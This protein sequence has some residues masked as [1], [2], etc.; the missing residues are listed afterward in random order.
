MFGS[1]FIIKY[2]KNNTK[3]GKLYSRHETG[4]IAVFNPMGEIKPLYFEYQDIN[5]KLSQIKIDRILDSSKEHF[6]GLPTIIYICETFINERNVQ[7]GLRYHVTGHY[8]E[9]L[10]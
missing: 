3:K 1:S 4:V 6:A 7:C 8:W 10:Y 5:G 9:L 2:N